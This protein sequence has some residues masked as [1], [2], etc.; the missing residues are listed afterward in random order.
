M[1]RERRGSCAA[2]TCVYHQWTYDHDGELVGVPYR[3]GLGCWGFPADF[4]LADHGLR[5]LRVTVHC[6]IVFGTLSASGPTLAEFLGKP[7]LDRLARIFNRP[8]Q[9][10]GYQRQHIRGNW[11]LMNENVKD[12]YHG[13]L[14]H[15][16]NSKFGSSAPRSAAT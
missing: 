9:V 3:N 13:A 5:R 16:F 1:T 12:A 2:H 4:A 10:L 6:G 7:I 11:K 8:V 15:A 14:L